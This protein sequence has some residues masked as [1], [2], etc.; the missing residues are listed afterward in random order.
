MMNKLT[1]A[2]LAVLTTSLHAGPA[3]APVPQPAE[4]KL[5]TWDVQDRVRWW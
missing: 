5:I 2:V 4:R 1:L 3:T